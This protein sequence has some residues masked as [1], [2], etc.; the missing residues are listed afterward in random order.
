MRNHTLWDLRITVSKLAARCKSVIGDSV[1][2]PTFAL[3]GPFCLGRRRIPFVF[4]E[5][6]GATGQVKTLP[7]F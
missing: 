3:A 2:N 5:G 1:V 7:L 6:K 4:N